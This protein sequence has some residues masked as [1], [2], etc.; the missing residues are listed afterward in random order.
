MKIFSIVISIY[1]SKII[2]VLLLIATITLGWFYYTGEANSKHTLLFGGLVAGLIVAIIQFLFSWNEHHSIERI[3]ALGIKDILLH[4]EDRSFYKNLISAS[5]VRISIMG[6]T[7]S[8]FMDHFADKQSDRPETRV[9]L[10]ALS[11]RVKV[12]ILVPER[13]FLENEDDKRN[14]IKAKKQFAKVA[15]EHKNFKYRYFS[16]L[17]T[18][19]LVV[20]DEKSI[21]GPVFPK[22][23]SKDTPCIFITTSSPY[24]EKYL[25]YFE[26]EWK[27]A[28]T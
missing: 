26:T 18:H 12:R 27:N 13:K 14:F 22:V 16:H 11:R 3:N 21:I 1:L 25:D 23:R 20:V 24:A 4:R 10:D 17:P 19:S 2:L 5:K 28:K 8:R 7:A 9:L 15:S 6:V